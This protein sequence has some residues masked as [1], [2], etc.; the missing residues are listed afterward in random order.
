M[1]LDTECVACLRRSNGTGKFLFATIANMLFV[2]MRKGWKRYLGGF[3][4]LS[5]VIFERNKFAYVG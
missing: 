2:S 5:C 3:E 1:V 4:D